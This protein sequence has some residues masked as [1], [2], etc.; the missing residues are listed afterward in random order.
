M[1]FP[2]L[3][4]QAGR[5]GLSV[6]LLGLLG[7]TDLDTSVLADWLPEWELMFKA[8]FDTGKAETRIHPARLNYY[9]KSFEALLSSDAPTTL[10]WP[11]L[12]TWTH[13]AIALRVEEIAPWQAACTTLG[14]TGER[15]IERVEGLRSLPG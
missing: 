9:K 8:A 14:L 2:A 7:A 15:F 1:L 6:G 10:L 5:P 4:E 13:A 12:N 11:L 3:A